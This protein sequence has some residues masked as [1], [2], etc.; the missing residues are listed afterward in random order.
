MDVV[1]G[2]QVRHVHRRAFTACDA[3]PV[4]SDAPREAKIATGA[5]AVGIKGVVASA[6]A[7]RSVGRQLLRLPVIGPVGRRGVDR[8]AAEGD[9]VITDVVP[10][11]VDRVLKLVVAVITVVV[12]ELDL[13]K[14]VQ[15]HADLNAIA[16]DL[17]INAILD[18]VDL[19][20][21]IAE[22]VDLNAAVKH[23]DLDAVA[24][25]LDIDAILA[26]VDLIGL[27]EEIIEGVDLP[28]I[29][30]DASTSVTADVMTDVR[31]TSERADDAVANAIGR[32]LRRKVEAPDE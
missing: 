7:A 9:R 2:S 1:D 6:E 8:L 32:L 14:L 13:T 19:N 28:D 20:A 31:S 4:S 12:A 18:R 15:E 29:I 30:R 16:G 5:V 17:D 10:V 3:Y 25:G 23:V 21:V 11:L 24:G 26:R 22:R 27:A